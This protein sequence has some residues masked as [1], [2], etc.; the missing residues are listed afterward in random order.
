MERPRDVFPVPGG[1]EKH[2]IGPLDSGFQNANL[3]KVNKILPFHLDSSTVKPGCYW[4][5]LDLFFN[6]WSLL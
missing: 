1:P 2:K 4:E 3:E 6:Y 5:Q